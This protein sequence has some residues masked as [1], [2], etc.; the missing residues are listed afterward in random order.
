MA[1]RKRVVLDGPAA[2][3]VEL[4]AESAGISPA[5]LVK[6]ALLRE[7]EAQRRGELAPD[8]SLLT[9][10]LTGWS[11][12]GR[13]DTPGQPRKDVPRTIE[14]SLTGAPKNYLRDPE[15]VDDPI[16]Y[17]PQRRSAQPETAMLGQLYMIYLDR[18]GTLYV[19]GLANSA[20]FRKHPPP[21]ATDLTSFFNT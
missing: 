1:R 17:W 5:E 20:N 13:V 4:L 8:E 3:A 6:R 19:R 18:H 7:E 2:E 14:V 11:P 16:P 12:L 21:S 9:R 10:I 15:P